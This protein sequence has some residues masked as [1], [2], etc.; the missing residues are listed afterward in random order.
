MAKEIES[1]IRKH[2]VEETGTDTAT[3]I[4]CIREIETIIKDE[5]GKR[6]LS[7]VSSHA[8]TNIQ[9]NID[10]SLGLFVVEIG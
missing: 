8:L 3:A 1:I 6:V 5:M 9:I 2:F 7:K 10:T 4:R